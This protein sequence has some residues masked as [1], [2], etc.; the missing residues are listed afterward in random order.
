[1][2]ELFGLKPQDEREEAIFTLVYYASRIILLALVVGGVC[3]LGWINTDRYVSKK[4]MT[5]C[6]G[7]PATLNS[8][9][10]WHRK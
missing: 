8:L 9:I 6:L 10:H 1:M 7:T 2:L 4:I 3:F 5:S